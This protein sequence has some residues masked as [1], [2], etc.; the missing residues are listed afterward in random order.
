MSFFKKI[1]FVS[2]E[3]CLLNAKCL[4]TFLL[5]KI[6]DIKHKCDNTFYLR[7]MGQRRHL[8]VG[9]L[10]TS[11]YIHLFKRTDVSHRCRL[12]RFDE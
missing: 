5:G 6:H 2:V 12:R 3:T 4:L 11:Q 1:V 8:V 9:P 10:N 7:L